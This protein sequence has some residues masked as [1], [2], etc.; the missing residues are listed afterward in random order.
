MLCKNSC[1]WN[2]FWNFDFTST[3]GVHCWY[4]CKVMLLQDFSTN[5]WKKQL[6]DN[7]VIGGY[8]S[9]QSSSQ[10]VHPVSLD[11]K[12]SIIPAWYFSW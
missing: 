3:V 12:V 1:P 2:I 4:I 7:L 6:E 5:F 11:V 8:A 9:V 10:K